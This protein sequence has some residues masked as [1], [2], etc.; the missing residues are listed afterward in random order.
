MI[1]I[2]FLKKYAFR[3][4]AAVMFGLVAQ[5]AFAAS[6][7]W[8]ND[9]SGDW[10]NTNNWL[11]GIV[12]D[13]AGNTG[14]FSA[15]DLAGDLA[16]TLD[17]PHTISTLIFGDADST[18][19]HNWFLAGPNTLTLGAA[20]LID[21]TNETA[22]FSVP[23]A[24]TSG[25]TKVGAGT[26]IF[27]G[28]NSYTGTTLISDGVV[29]Y[30]GASKSTSGGVFNVGGAT[31]SAVVNLNTTGS[32]TN[33]GG[34]YGVGGLQ[35]DATDTGVGVI[36]I[37]A[38]TLNNG[39][40]NNYT[41][42][43]TGSQN[44]NA[45]GATSYGCINLSSGGVFNTLGSSGIRVGAGGLGVFN[46]T[47]GA[48]NASRYLAVGSQANGGTTANA[49]GTGLVNFLGGTA[50]VSGSY[51]VILNDKSG[52]VAIF[53]LG[54]EAGGTARFTEPSTASGGAFEFMDQGGAS[55]QAILNLNSGTLQLAAPMYRTSTG[56][57]AEINWNGGKFQALNN[58][59]LANINNSFPVI[60]VYN[61]GVVIDSQTYSVTNGVQLVQPAGNGIYPADGTIAVS[62]GGGGSYL[63]LPYV[64]VSGGSGSNAMA[65]ANLSGGVVSG[66]TLTSPGQNYVAGDVLTFT[67]AG[68]GA[69]TPA[70][71]FNY[72]LQAA[73][74]AANTAGGLTKFGSG[75]LVLTEANTYSGATTVEAGTL[76]VQRDGGLGN[77]TV[78][79]GSSATLIL[80]DGATNG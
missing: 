7:V 73:D 13:G 80:E 54:T 44:G 55:A 2:S 23:V 35:G 52:G 63:G 6:G 39:N 21:V 24:G 42:V 29:N 22:T 46:Q 65:I 8:T 10:G 75:K 32:L 25:L 38:G 53:N 9:V 74:V 56:G 40:N 3:A 36:N 48:L 62:S 12:A 28:T 66:V 27:L 58:M 37:L 41:E 71:A 77:G 18:P 33:N 51:R 17:A 20:P 59:N 43:G 16:V 15:V 47:G 26:L 61:G 11:G 64:S 79:V 60:D 5:S 31:G 45:L 78:N 70:G 19:Q 76:D 50:T 67:F 1:T 57:N 72:T 49:G 69:A 30:G 14:D 68:G 34:S 4:W